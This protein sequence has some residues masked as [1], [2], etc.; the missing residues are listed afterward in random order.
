MIYAS[1]SLLVLWPIRDFQ[2][3]NG[4]LRDA[5][6]IE[7]GGD[8]R[9]VGL[10][11]PAASREALRITGP[12]ALWQGKTPDEGLRLHRRLTSHDPILR[13]LLGVMV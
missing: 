13:V 5:D 12:C 11:A 4:C 9:L 2:V 6:Q 8:G 3:T 1:L 10:R 7:G